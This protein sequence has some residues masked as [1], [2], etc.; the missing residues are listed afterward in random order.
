MSTSKSLNNSM[1]KNSI[2]DVWLRQRAELESEFLE[3]GN[4]VRVADPVITQA[5]IATPLTLA[6]QSQSASANSSTASDKLSSSLNAVAAKQFIEL[7]QRLDHE[8]MKQREAFLQELSR[9]RADFTRDLAVREAAWATQ[10]D[11]EWAALQN[12]KEVHAATVQNL[13][14]KLA[15]ER[16]REH[17]E[18]LQWRRQA[19]VELTEARRVFEQDRLQ[20][21]TEFARQREAELERLR[22]ERAEFEAHVRRAKLEL[23]DT[24]QRQD[25][26][27]RLAQ[28]AHTSQIQ[29][30]R[31]ELEQLRAA[32][33]DKFRREQD[34]VN[35]G[36]RCFE[37]SLS[38][39]NQDLKSAQ[40]EI[41]AHPVENVRHNAP[42]DVGPLDSEERNTLPFDVPRRTTFTDLNAEPVLLSLDE[43]RERLNQI[44]DSNQQKVV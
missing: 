3:V 18:L 29:A 16:V 32:W 33:T 2:H 12:A 34:V 38:R 7:Q 6:P 23:S 39:F 35:S 42:H 40:Q 22:Q 8:L 10:R 20:Q 37:Q 13:Q 30:E 11:Q 27:L 15:T 21:Q 1:A 17:D 31:A 5:V 4:D 28:E 9:Q 24:R 41:N 44:K 36:L 43:I 26:D 14:T 25:H 19:E